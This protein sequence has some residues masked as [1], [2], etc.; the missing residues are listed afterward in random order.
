[1]APRLYERLAHFTEGPIVIGATLTERDTHDDIPVLSAPCE[2]P[3]GEAMKKHKKPVLSSKKALRV[4]SPLLPSLLLASAKRRTPMR[5]RAFV[6]R[7]K[8]RTVPRPTSRPAGA[9]AKP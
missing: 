8:E 9:S 3:V 4:E 6:Q 7:G 2:E 1:M 5:K